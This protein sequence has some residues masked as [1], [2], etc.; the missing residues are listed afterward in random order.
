MGY[1]SL[2]SDYLGSLN[3]WLRDL[4]GHRVLV[5]ELI[6]NADDS[7]NATSMSFEILP[8]AFIIEDDGGFAEAWKNCGPTWRSSA[9]R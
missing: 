5:N 4:R 3:A 9:G 1:L 2:D 7:Q 6:Q 8:D